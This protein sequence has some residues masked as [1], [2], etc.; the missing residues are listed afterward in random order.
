MLPA[1]SSYPSNAWYHA[2][3]ICQSIALKWHLHADLNCIAVILGRW[4][5]SSCTCE[6]SR[7]PLLWIDYSESLP[8]FLTG[9]PLFLLICR[10]L[11]CI[12]D[13]NPFSESLL[14]LFASCGLYLGVLCWIKRLSISN[15]TRPSTNPYMMD[16]GKRLLSHLIEEEV[17]GWFKAI[18]L[19]LRPLDWNPSSWIAVAFTSLILGMLMSYF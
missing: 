8:I 2:F 15:P 9:L 10:S 11:L 12:L 4:S 17:N 6:S 14:S 1:V 3:S 13:R 19:D 16:P 18:H 7:L 5:I